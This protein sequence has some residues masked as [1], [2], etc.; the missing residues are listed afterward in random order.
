[1]ETVY[2]PET[3]DIGNSVVGPAFLQCQTVTGRL[4]CDRVKEW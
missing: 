3:T 1:M 4:L 2:A